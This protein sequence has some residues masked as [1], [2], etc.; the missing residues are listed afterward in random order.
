MDLNLLKVFD[1]MMRERNVTQAAKRLGVSQPAVS[2]ALARLRLHFQDDLFLRS[3]KGMTASARALDLAGPI[4]QMLALLEDTLDVGEF[5]PATSQRTFRISMVDIGT[6]VLLPKLAGY[7]AKHAPGINLRLYQA[8]GDALKRLDKQESDFALL[9]AMVVPPGYGLLEMSDIEF[10][11][12]LR[13]GHALATGEMTLERYC[14]FPHLI[15]TV[16]G[17]AR[18]DVD[19]MLDGHGLRRRVAMTIN[20]FAN[21]VGIVAQTD[22]V[23]AV[24]RTFAESHAPLANLVVRDA[25]FDARYRFYKSALVWNK[26]LTDHPALHWFRDTIGKIGSARTV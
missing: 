13:P 21:G 4:R 24:P 20:S 1:A 9:P 18:S 2:N 22:M 23:F 15:V 26:R 14:Q 11:L 10:V 8:R 5:D 19:E 3:G 12:L 25:P 6:S 16:T 17:N 7:L